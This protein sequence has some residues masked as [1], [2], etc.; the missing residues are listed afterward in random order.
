MEPIIN[1]IQNNINN[2]IKIKMFNDKPHVRYITWRISGNNMYM[3]DCGE[4]YA[5][6]YTIHTM[7]ELLDKI[8]NS[9]SS[10]T[11]EVKIKYKDDTK[12]IINL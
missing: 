10:F 12:D 6:V 1:K 7:E 9:F 8:K 3:Y 5:T 11:K 4:N 2:I